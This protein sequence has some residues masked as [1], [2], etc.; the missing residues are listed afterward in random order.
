MSKDSFYGTKDPFV[1]PRPGESL[2]AMAGR[3]DGDD[4]LIAIVSAKNYSEAEKVFEQN[5]R[6]QVGREE[7]DFYIVAGILVVQEGILTN[8]DSAMP[9]QE[10]EESNTSGTH[11][12]N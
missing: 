2:Y 10:P 1:R 7:T 12:E 11:P 8:T 6:D 9:D 3:F 5:M 4:E